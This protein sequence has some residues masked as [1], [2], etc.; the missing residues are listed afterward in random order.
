M[1]LQTVKSPNLRQIAIT[2]D[3]LTAFNLPVGGEIHWEWQDLD[4]LLVQLWTSRSILPKI[5]FE[6]RIRGNPLGEL[7]PGFLPELISMGA[8]SM[9]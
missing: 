7:P 9:I 3:S 2:V 6:R 8:V 1:S 5:K 4:R